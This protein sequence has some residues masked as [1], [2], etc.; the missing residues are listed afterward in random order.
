M[1][2]ILILD[3]NPDTRLNHRVSPGA[4]VFRI[5][6][7]SNGTAALSQMRIERFDAVLMDLQMPGMEGVELPATLRQGAITTPAIIITAFDDLPSEA[8]AMRLGTI[9]FLRKPPGI[10]GTGAARFAQAAGEQPN[11]NAWKGCLR[12][13]P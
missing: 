7:A 2:R 6:E 5:S 1:K 11:R 8:R 12:P 10:A 4:D 3:G 9:D 13:V